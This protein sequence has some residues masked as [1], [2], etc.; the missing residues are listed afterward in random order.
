MP[1]SA[2]TSPGVVTEEQQSWLV[3]VLHIQPLRPKG[4]KALVT[5]NL[6]AF[7]FILTK[8]KYGNNGGMYL[9]H[10]Y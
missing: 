7:L 3:I 8:V 5:P 9:F 4:L 1:T 6:W 10:E 2:S